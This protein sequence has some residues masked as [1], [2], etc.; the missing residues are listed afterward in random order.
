L[1]VTVDQKAN[2][3]TDV[4]SQKLSLQWVGFIDVDYPKKSI[5]FSMHLVRFMFKYSHLK[6]FC[7]SLVEN[8]IFSEHPSI[9]QTF[10]FLAIVNEPIVN[11]GLPLGRVKTL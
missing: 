5:N 10:G 7:S 6:L 9:S 11:Y 8:E 1:K 3:G 2:F 4:I